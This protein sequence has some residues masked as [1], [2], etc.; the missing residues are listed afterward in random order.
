MLEFFIQVKP[1]NWSHLFVDRSYRV[2]SSTALASS[3][4]LIVKSKQKNN[5]KGDTSIVLLLSLTC[6]Y[7]LAPIMIEM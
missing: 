7:V 4:S 6:G 5:E 2:L 3:L 1:E